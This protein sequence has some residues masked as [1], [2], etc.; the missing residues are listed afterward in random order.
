MEVLPLSF[1]EL[2][3]LVGYFSAAVLLLG[4]AFQFIIILLNDKCIS[5]KL[6]LV[7]FVTQL[8]AFAATIYLWLKWP[9]GL[10]II[11]GPILFPALLAETLI[12]PVIMPLFNYSILGR[13]RRPDLRSTQ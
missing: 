9:A 11:Y 13:K 6:F 2:L 12:I 5:I 3:Q 8:L 10:K 4:I 7:I 1:K